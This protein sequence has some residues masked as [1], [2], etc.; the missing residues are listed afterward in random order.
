MS[1]LKPNA[2]QPPSVSDQTTQQL[3]GTGG[4]LALNRQYGTINQQGP[5]SSTTWDTPANGIWTQHQTVDPQVEALYRQ[6]MAS[7]AGKMGAQAGA[8]PTVAANAAAGFHPNGP[9]VQ[10]SI[11]QTPVMTGYSRSGMTAIPGAADQNAWRNQVEQGLYGDFTAQADP[12]FARETQNLNT[13]LRDKGFTPGD[14]GFNE[15][16]NLLA[17]QHNT[18][19]QGAARDA[20]TQATQQQGQLLGQSLSARMQQGNEAQQDFT[21]YNAAQG[22]KFGEGQAAGAFGNQA[23][24]QGYGQS[25]QNYMAPLNYYNALNASAPS[26]PSAGTGQ[27]PTSAAGAPNT[28]GANQLTYQG[29]QGQYNQNMGTFNNLLNPNLYTGIGQ[30]GNSIMGWLGDGSGSDLSSQFFGG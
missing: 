5:F 8:L 28:L 1:F 18:A 2:P 4:A 3:L 13:S 29:Q 19:Y 27:M 24:Q 25:Y 23:Q 12:R 9:A 7:N 11:P 16:S 30:I 15:A 17:Q 10:N 20:R 21:N 6:Y 26:M 22:V 14:A